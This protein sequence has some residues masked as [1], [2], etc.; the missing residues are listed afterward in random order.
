MGKINVGSFSTLYDPQ[1]TSNARTRIWRNCNFGLF[2]GRPVSLGDYGILMSTNM[3]KC[4]RRD[5]IQNHTQ[6]APSDEGRT[7][8]QCLHAFANLFYVAN[9]T[10]IIQY[11]TSLFPICQPLI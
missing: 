5:N 3:T 2:F 7:A 11:A 6:Q 8:V 9:N 1:A 4:I 10:L